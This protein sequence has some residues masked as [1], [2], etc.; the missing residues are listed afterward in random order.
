MSQRKHLLYV[1]EIQIVT[2][3]DMPL[4]HQAIP[5]HGGPHFG[6]RAIPEGIF[7]VI[8]DPV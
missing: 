1:F 3:I 4:V 5:N 8:A 7:A 6:S 2:L